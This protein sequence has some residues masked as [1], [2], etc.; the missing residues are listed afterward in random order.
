MSVSTTARLQFL[1]KNPLVQEIYIGKSPLFF[2]IRHHIQTLFSA[3]YQ[4]DGDSYQNESALILRFE[5]QKWLVSPL[6]P[7]IALF[8]RCGLGD[9]GRIRRQ[10]GEAVVQTVE[11]LKELITSYSEE[12]SVLNT[13]FIRLFIDLVCEYPQD[14]IKIWC[15]QKERN[16]FRDLLEGVVDLDDEVFISTLSEYRK[17]P[18]ADV[19]ILFGPL[20]TSGLANVP[21]ALITSPSY[22]RLVRFIWEKLPDEE[23][24]ANDPVL[25]THNYLAALRT[26][27]TTVS[28][29]SVAVG[30]LKEET[31]LVNEFMLLDKRVTIG[32]PLQQCVLV[33]LPAEYG[34][35]LRPG[36][37][38]LVFNPQGTDSE[39]IGYRQLG[40]V[41][42]GEYLLI[43]DADANLG[44][45][46]VD[47]T[48]APLA[49]LWKKALVN[50]WRLHPSE[51][52]QKMQQAG[53][54]LLDLSRA[55]QKWIAMNG[56][57]IHAPL[58]KKH[59]EALLTKVLDPELIPPLVAN[60]KTI[61]GWRQAWAEVETSRGVAIQHGSVE[62]A[63]VNEQLLVELRKELPAIR[64]MISLDNVFRHPLQSKTGLIGSVAFKP[65]I[66]LSTDFA[67]PAELLEKTLKL[68]IAEQYRIVYGSAHLCA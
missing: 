2:A 23:G 7:D 43:H 8:Q 18:P 10:W 17:S 62:H 24:F 26:I 44:E 5:M 29:S 64:S 42:A 33:E 3:I 51:C 46:S 56:T 35:L 1:E 48:K 52:I 50:A 15:H 67:A 41:E 58:R 32:K 12:G 38:L 60:G 65:V 47:A 25:P 11:Q 57:V 4:P 53:I 55:V 36:S 61:P 14:R 28:G 16:L 37:R 68:P 49:G 19:L 34:V 13:E 63:I 54:G 20:R 31:V 30:L 39:M 6:M 21:A 22:H 45:I 66:N 9:Y 27:R 59:F 40:D